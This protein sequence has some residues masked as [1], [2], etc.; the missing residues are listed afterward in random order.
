[1]T[2]AR[3]SSLQRD[4]VHG[5]TLQREAEDGGA[6]AKTLLLFNCEIVEFSDR[7]CSAGPKTAVPEPKRSAARA[8]AAAAAGSCRTGGGRLWAAAD[9]AAA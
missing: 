2:A 4:T 8:A 9:V 6:G 1:M 5:Y 7:P 3:L